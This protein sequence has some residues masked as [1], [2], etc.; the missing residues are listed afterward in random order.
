MSMSNNK[1]FLIELTNNLYRLTLLF[2]KKEPLRYKMREKAIKILEEP[3]EKDLAVLDKYFEV[4]LIQ[5][6]VSFA[7]MLAVKTK[8]DNLIGELTNKEKDTDV[9]LSLLA[10]DTPSTVNLKK[11]EIQVISTIADDQED[12]ISSVSLEEKNNLFSIQQNQENFINNGTTVNGVNYRQEK[13][14][15]FL[16]ENGRAQVWQIKEIMPDITKRTL[17]RDFEYMLKQGMIRRIGERNDTFYQI[18]VNQ[19]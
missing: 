15:E 2:P 16:K 5:K 17:R 8:Y 10:E 3:N 12:S 6:W 14:L 19:A 13:I 7:E 4:A 1:D 18:K 9:P 11:D